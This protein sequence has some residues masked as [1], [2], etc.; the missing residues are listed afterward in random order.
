MYDKVTNDRVVY[1]T[2]N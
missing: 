1:H 2:Y